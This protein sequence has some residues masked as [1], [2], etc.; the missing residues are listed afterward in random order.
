M[1]NR[2]ASLCALGLLLAAFPFVAGDDK[3]A[4]PA[5][6]DHSR[7]LVYRDADNKEHPVR[8]KED[9]LQRRRHILAGMEQAMGPLPDRSRLPPLD[10]EIGEK[11]DGE[12][13]LRLTIS[14]VAD[15]SDRVPAYLYLPANRP[16][17]ERRPAILALHPTGPAGKGIVDDRGP[18]PNRGYAKELARRGYVVLAPDYPSFGDYKYDF[19]ADKYVSGTMKGIVNHIRGVDLLQA[20]DEVDPEKIGVIGHSLGGHNAMFVAVFDERLKVI[21]SSCGWTPFHN[22]YGGKIAG[23]TGPVYMPR[24]KETYGLD[25]D[26]VP[27][28]FY[29]VVAALAPRTFF[30]VSPVRDSNFDV[31]GVRKAEPAARQVFDLLGAADNLEVKYPD[32]E[33]DFPDEVRQAAY[34]LFDK[35]FKYHPAGEEDFS[36]E[37]PRIPPH[38][39]AD[40]LATFKTVPGFRMEQAAAEPLVHSP[41][42]LSFDENGRMYVVEMIDYS[43]QDKEFLGTV[44]LLEDTDQDGRFDKSTVFA[45][46][47]SWPTAITCYDGGVFVGAA[48]DIFYLKDTDG[49]GRADVR[50][51]VFTGFGRGNVQGL[52]N[53]F[54]WGLDNR[55]HGAT[56]SSG[57][58]IVRPDVA[59]AKPIVVSGRD[60]AFDPRTLELA[61]TSGGAQHGMSFDDWGRKFLSSNSDHIQL[62]MYEDRYLVRNPYLAAP[63]PRLSI[64]ADGPQAEVFRISPVEPWRIVRTRLRVSGAVPGPVEGGGRAA[65]YFTGATGVTIYRG[66]AWPAAYRGQAFVGDV[67]SNI[68][69][70]KVLEPDGVALIARRADEK[71]EFVAS[72]DIWF[73]PAQ[74]ANAPDGNL[75]II[76]VYREVIEHPASLPPVIKKHLDLTSGR[77]RGR[78]YRVVADGYKQRPLSRLGKAT[79]AELVATLGHRNGWHRDTAARLLYERG[80]REA[81]GPLEKLAAS[82]PLPEG[83]MHALYALAALNSLSPAAILSRLA[84]EHPRVREHAVRLAETVADDSPEVRERLVALADDD[85]PRVRYQLA[86]T[87]GALPAAIRTA[88]L[89]KIL[90]RDGGDRWVRL[91]AFSSLADGAADVL[92]AL[93]GDSPF[94]SSAAGRGVLAELATLIGVQARQNEVLAV[95]KALDGFPEESKP[96]ATALVVGLSEGLARSGSPLRAQIAAR[97]GK[98]K[99]LLEELLATSRKVAGDD[100]RSPAERVEAT[101]TLGL[102]TFAEG[103]DL[104]PKLLGTRQPQEVQLAALAVLGRFSDPEI[105]GILIEQWPTFSPKLRTAALEAVFSRGEWLLRFLDA[106]EKDDIPASDLEPA[107]VRLLETHA[108]AAVREKAKG[109]AAR[110]KL[111]RRQDVLEA[112]K[113]ALTL[114]GDATKGKAHFQKV[115]SVCHRL[116]SVGTEIGPNL[117]TLQNRGAESILLNVLDPN[118]EVNPQY[119]N[120]ILVTTEGKSIT[121]IVSAETA[122]SVTLKRQENATD[123]VLRANIDE[124]RSTGLSIMPEGVEKQLDQQG[125]ADLIAYLL[126]VK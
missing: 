106:V 110:L 96:Q 74:F 46:K 37:L 26:K 32:C 109:V 42:A 82:S 23:W 114:T 10:V 69:H 65:G 77:D 51:V 125:M 75:Y 3:P 80:D 83:R 6:T 21:V 100:Q 112:Y 5:Y 102:A 33:H 88:P 28:D 91:A 99:E 87:L 121:G 55:I 8:T 39:P 36:D 98:A 2:I 119:V 31:A 95:L 84:D 1:H 11:F 85:D 97:P 111:G 67:G 52:F 57:G 107:R 122:T 19:D 59:G 124:L 27:F 104:L 14:Y 58:Q 117:A 68:V 90:K 79:T 43:E 118:R 50:K 108:N 44:R 20:R 4:T 41:V 56:S 29:E 62:V 123:T 70:R 64:A 48:P 76:D 30:S 61:P 103:R 66:D 126:S 120:Y 9:W 12:G 113:P 40:A 53:S 63:G 78:I 22:Y 49:D 13:Y 116:E 101:R 16:K 115:C 71:R 73:R 47:L 7:L 17:D 72:T 86:F 81:V 38:E 89:T 60:F 18:R 15:G 34:A 25:P 24:L 45:E 92:A 93:A 54:H 105:A 35:V 94:R